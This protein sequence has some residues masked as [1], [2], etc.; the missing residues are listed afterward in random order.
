MIHLPVASSGFRKGPL[1][2]TAS[3]VGLETTLLCLY[4]V[5]CME[6]P[7]HSHSSQARSHLGHE[8][9]LQEILDAREEW[10][11]WIW[12]EIHSPTKCAFEGAV[13]FLQLPLCL[14]LP[15]LISL[16]LP[17]AHLETQRPQQSRD[18]PA[19]TGVTVNSNGGKE[20]SFALSVF[21]SVLQA[22]MKPA[23]SY[24]SLWGVHTFFSRIF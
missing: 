3:V 19:L 8:S 10:E 5:V 14:L 13:P 9:C 21:V 24:A 11:R 12:R 6:S 2:P 16:V 4:S 15:G 20:Q 18:L 1:V 7:F 23:W 17:P 22:C